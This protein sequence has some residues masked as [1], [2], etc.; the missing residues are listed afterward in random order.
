MLHRP[1]TVAV[2]TCPIEILFLNLKYPSRQNVASQTFQI[3]LRAPPSISRILWGV[4]SQGKNLPKFYTV[5]CFLIFPN[6]FVLNSI[7][8]KI[9]VLHHGTPY[10]VITIKTGLKTKVEITS[11]TYSLISG[12]YPFLHNIVYSLIT[13]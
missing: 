11:F 5:K 7:E 6:L 3:L 2:Q 9:N 4:K 1:H 10:I 12:T 8:F 13:F